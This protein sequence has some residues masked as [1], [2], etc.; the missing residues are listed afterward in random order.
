[1]QGR[2]Q[3]PTVFILEG[4]SVPVKGEK[5]IIFCPRHSEV[6]TGCSIPIFIGTSRIANEWNCS[7][8]HSCKGSLFPSVLPVVGQSH[9]LLCC[10]SSSRILPMLFPGPILWGTACSNLSAVPAIFSDSKRKEWA[11][12]CSGF[13]FKI[14][15]SPFKICYYS[16]TRVIRYTH[17]AVLKPSLLATQVLQNIWYMAC[18]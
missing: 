9:A 15:P 7:I 12:P 17:G 1:M 4:S 10:P 13:E 18:I 5:K 3:W 14:F 16:V 6:Y 2:G 8:C 11:L